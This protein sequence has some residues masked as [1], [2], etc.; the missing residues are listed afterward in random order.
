MTRSI[1]IS[2]CKLHSAG[3][4]CLVGATG[5]EPVTPSLS[6]CPLAPRRK[7]ENPLFSSILRYRQRDCKPVRRFARS[8]INQRKFRSS[9]KALRKFCGTFRKTNLGRWCRWGVSTP[10]NALARDHHRA[11]RA[12]KQ[13]NST[14]R[15]RA[16]A[17]PGRPCRGCHMLPQTAPRGPRQ[18]RFT[19]PARRS[20]RSLRPARPW[21]GRGR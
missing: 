2:S 19:H 9:G 13:T 16:R 11:G 15:R 10:G 7:H 4:L 5:L 8:C 18:K 1:R 6:K 21:P 20:G 17:S 14:R 3:D 12:E